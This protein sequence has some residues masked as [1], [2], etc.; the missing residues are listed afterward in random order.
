MMWYG[1]EY[2]H[3]EEGALHVWRTRHKVTYTYTETYQQVL[4]NYVK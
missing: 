4:D 2:G 1:D 3:N